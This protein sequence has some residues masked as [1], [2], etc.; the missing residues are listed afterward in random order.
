MWDSLADTPALKYEYLLAAS[1]LGGFRYLLLLDTDGSALAIACLCFIKT[2]LDI[3]KPNSFIKWVR[4]FYPNFL[5]LTVLECGLPA[6]SGCGFAIKPGA[7]RWEVLKKIDDAITRESS[8]LVLRDFLKKD[9]DLERLGYEQIP[10]L[11][12]TEIHIRW[13]S[14]DKYLASLRSGYRQSI[15]KDLKKLQCVRIEHTNNFLNYTEQMLSLWKQTNCKAFEYDREML[16]E[17][18]FK[19]L[20]NIALATLFWLDD[21][22]V[23]FFISLSDASTLYPLWVGID[24]EVNNKIPLVFGAYYETVKLAISLKKTKLVLGETTYEPKVRIGAQIVP[25][26]MY[27]KI[28]KWKMLTKVLA[29]IARCAT[30][31]HLHMQRFVFKNN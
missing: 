10:N 19:G 15:T 16:N 25:L 29:F 22:L 24:Y 1:K 18:Y 8:I 4:S 21:K 17:E 7:D 23:A 6:T 26:Y 5:M 20:E 9:E 14:F 30:P 12:E 2:P 31:C 3:F 11:E 13:N 28:P 27:L